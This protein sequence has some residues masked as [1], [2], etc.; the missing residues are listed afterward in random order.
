MS[1]FGR[2]Y[3]K[4][5][6]YNTTVLLEHAKVEVN[7]IQDIIEH[8]SVLNSCISKIAMGQYAEVTITLNLFKYDNPQAKFTELLAY[9]NKVVTQFFQYG[10]G[11]PFYAQKTNTPC[12][13]YISQVTPKYLMQYQYP[14]IVEIK[15]K[16]CEY[17]YIVPTDEPLP[18]FIYGYGFN[19]GQNYGR[20]L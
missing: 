9:K 1:I 19:Y 18:Y 5:T 14:D 2:S 16:S 4:F 3:P 11:N 15:M 6:L 8:K 10:D 7:Y 20:Q 17:I 12:T 13:F